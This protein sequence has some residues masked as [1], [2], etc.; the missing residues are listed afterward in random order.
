MPPLKVTLP[1][2]QSHEYDVSYV[3][4][5][6]LK[7]GRYEAIVKVKNNKE[8]SRPSDAAIINI[9]KKTWDFIKT[10]VFS[11]ATILGTYHV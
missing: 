2:T 3:I 7:P 9:G 8:W 1:S 10:I 4:Q 11:S 6:E 5:E